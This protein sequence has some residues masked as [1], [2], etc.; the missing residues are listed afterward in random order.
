M[1]LMTSR[2]A[3][4]GRM[5]LIFRLL[6]K[7]LL[8]LCA[9]PV[10]ILLASIVWTIIT[11]VFDL[12]ST[13][14]KSYAIGE[15]TRITNLLQFSP[16]ANTIAY[17]WRDATYKDSWTPGVRTRTMTDA[18]QVRW[19]PIASPRQEKSILLDSIDL[20]PEGRPYC[21]LDGWAFFSPDSQHLAA[22]CLKYITIIDLKTGD[23]FKLHYG[24]ERF[25]SLRWYSEE[26]VVFSTIGNK[27]FSFWRLNI[28][29]I[30]EG[31]IKIYSQDDPDASF[32]SYI[33][34]PSLPFFR[35]HRYSPNGRFVFFSTLVNNKFAT[36]LVNLKTGRT[37][38]FP[39]NPFSFSWKPDGTEVLMNEFHHID[40]VELTPTKLYL[41]KTQTME[42][43]ELTEQFRVNMGKHPDI[44][45]ISLSSPLWTPDGKYVI[46]YRVIESP[47]HSKHIGY[48]IQL[49]PFKLILSRDTMIRWAPIPGWVFLQRGSDRDWINYGGNKTVKLIDWPSKGVWSPDRVHAAIVKNGKVVIVKPRFPTE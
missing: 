36:R 26:E 10:V 12:H 43:E 14:V 47:P 44:L 20:R 23:Y 27:R 42:I 4:S 25:P 41:I 3:K 21:K 29:K 24:G 32:D 2:T 22:V 33:S 19:F 35:R 40:G 28:N 13:V 30:N 15:H 8:V 18:L 1:Q 46:L 31:R 11:S 38:T 9:I 37:T 17:F 5:R 45:E 7:V 16:D 6:G 34:S 48:L 49:Q 39:I